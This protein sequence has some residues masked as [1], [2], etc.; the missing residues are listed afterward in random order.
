M[1]FPT[2]ESIGILFLIPQIMGPKHSFFF[3]SHSFHP[4]LLFSKN[5]HESL[6]NETLNLFIRLYVSTWSRHEIAFFFFLKGCCIYENVSRSLFIVLCFL[7]LSFIVSDAISW[8]LGN[9]W[10]S[11]PEETYG[12]DIE[13]T[14]TS[15]LMPI[16][17]PSPIKKTAAIFS[18]PLA[19]KTIFMAWSALLS[20][21]DG[22]YFSIKS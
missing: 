7:F 16:F 9:L 3:S 8:S 17:P 2:K 15:E 11:Q 12:I 20:Q 14:V 13:H 21:H 18:L 6:L 10:S 5:L 19:S 22:K 4:T 1:T